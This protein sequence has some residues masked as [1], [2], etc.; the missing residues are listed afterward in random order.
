MP[1]RSNAF[2]ELVALV[3]RSLAPRGAKV[4]ESALVPGQDDHVREIDILIES[5]MGP[6]AITI[7]VE[8]KDESRRMDITKFESIIG[9]YLTQSGIRVNQVVV[10]SRS[11][12]CKPVIKRAEREGIKLLTLEKA[13]GHEWAEHVPREMRISIG[14]HIAG[15]EVS[16][17]PLTSRASCCRRQS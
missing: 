11:G 3:E 13:M 9:K 6:Y 17:A 8:A 5:S 2:Q 16:H 4:T 14:A 10:V 1:A 7:A 15:I 12:F